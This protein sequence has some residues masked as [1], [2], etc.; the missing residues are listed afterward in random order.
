MPDT[1]QLSEAKRALLE[2]YLRGDAPQRTGINE[3]NGLVREKQAPYNDT[4]IEPALVPVVPINATGTKTP[5]FYS[6]VHV[7]GGAF[8]CFSLAD[9]LGPDQPFYILEPYC[10]TIKGVPPSLEEMAAEYVKAMRAVQPHGPYQ[11]GGFCGGGLI[12]FE[13]AHQLHRQGEE[14]DLL[15]LVEPVDG[16]GPASYRMLIRNFGGRLVRSLARLFGISRRQQ[17]DWF[18]RV[19]H[20]YLLARYSAYREREPKWLAPSLETLHKDWIGIFVW[21]ISA[22]K[23]VKYPG[24][25]TYFW[26][27]EEFIGRREWGRKQAEAIERE[28]HQIPGNHWSCRTEYL[29]ELAAELKTCLEQVRREE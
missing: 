10:F 2:K 7:D 28:V 25:V 1:P 19:R 26:A 11:L 3:L 13:M 27:K 12:V 22:Y 15:L 21:L 20:Y 14:V 18:M 17:L 16:P 24:K 6:H 23:P 29:S 4:P 5:F 8:Y 9:S